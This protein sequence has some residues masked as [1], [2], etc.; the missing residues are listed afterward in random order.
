[1][2]G[3]SSVWFSERQ[4]YSV[5]FTVRVNVASASIARY[6]HQARRFDG[7]PDGIVSNA[8]LKFLLH[9]QVTTPGDY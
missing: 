1:M 4:H 2:A 6:R 8:L 7:I 3:R 5:K 9:Q